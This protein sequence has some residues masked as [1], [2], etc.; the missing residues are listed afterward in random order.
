MSAATFTTEQRERIVR[1]AR[2][3]RR[4]GILEQGGDVVDLAT[5]TDNYF[6]HGLDDRRARIALRFIGLCAIEYPCRDCRE[7]FPYDP[8][9]DRCPLCVAALI[10][11]GRP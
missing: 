9:A 10:D 4:L 8:D 6:W 5:E 2:D 3:A 11:G 7:P 1:A